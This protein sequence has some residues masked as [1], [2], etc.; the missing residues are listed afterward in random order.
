MN[1]PVKGK[2]QMHLQCLPTKVKYIE[3][4]LCTEEG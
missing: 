3:D 1:L 2:D 4:P